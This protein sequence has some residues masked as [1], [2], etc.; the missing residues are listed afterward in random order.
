M[1]LKTCLITGANSGIGKAAAHQMIQHGY[2]TILACRNEEK[3]LAALKEIKLASGKNN[4]ELMIVDMALQSSIQELAKNYQDKYNHLDVLIHNAAIFDITQKEVSRTAEGI[5]SIWA[6]NHIGPVLLTK[7][8]SN[9]LEKSQQGRI[10]T[11]TSKGLIAKPFLKVDLADPEYKTRPYSVENAYYQSKLA[12]IMYTYWV[13][14]RF[15]NTNITANS[16]YVTAVQVDIDKYPDLPEILKKAYS[17]KSKFSISPEKM[18]E[19][20]THLATAPELSSETGKVYDEKMKAV[21]T[22]KYS[23]D[24]KNINDVMNLTMSYLTKVS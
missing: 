14:D 7:L 16:I 13:A 10:I 11:I 5:E 6:T 18:A 21:K 24:I 4:L 3:G 22:T 23:K 1:E 17:L 20:Y 8:L 15:K 12:Q 2:H 19:I 9:S